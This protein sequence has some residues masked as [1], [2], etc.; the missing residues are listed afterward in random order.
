MLLHAENCF[1][2][3]FSVVR[4]H[5]RELITRSRL[6][7]EDGS[8][9]GFKRAVLLEECL[10]AFASPMQR[11]FSVFDGYSKEICNFS[12]IEFRHIRQDNEDQPPTLTHAP[13]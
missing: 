2:R 3:Y 8:L 9:I 1:S 10:E 5:E 11:H 7:N 12:M 13:V 4:V 6:T